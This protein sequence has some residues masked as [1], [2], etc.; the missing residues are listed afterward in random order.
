MIKRVLADARDRGLTIPDVEKA[1]G[2]T[3][4]TFYRWRDGDW[5][6]DPSGSHV[7]NFFEGLGVSYR[8]AYNALDWADP[9][10]GAP[11]P[12]PELPPEVREI[13]R[14]LRDPAT[15]E[16]EKLFLRESL[17]MLAGRGGNSTGRR[18]QQAG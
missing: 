15:S 18:Q 17:R 3:K 8:L 4:S 6:R 14:K 5:T 13:L 10:A 1:T 12:E 2:V 9:D 7:R 16:Q 11:D